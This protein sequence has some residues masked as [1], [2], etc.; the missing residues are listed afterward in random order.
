MRQHKAVFTSL[1]AASAFAAAFTFAAP[2]QADPEGRWK[3]DAAGGCYFDAF[4]E[5]P[6]QCA[7]AEGRWKVDGGGN[8]YFDIN[9]S[10]PNQC[11]PSSR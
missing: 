1:V 10:G 11:V 5:G 4:D 2:A 6:D 8:C 9:D 3:L 7:A